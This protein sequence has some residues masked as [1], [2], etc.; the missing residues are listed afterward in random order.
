MSKAWAVTGKGPEST[1]WPGQGPE[2]YA[3]RDFVL[4]LY[5]EVTIATCC[6]ARAQHGPRPIDWAKRTDVVRGSFGPVGTSSRRSRCSGWRRGA[7]LE[8]AL[9]PQ[10]WVFPHGVDL[11]RVSTS[12]RLA[13][14]GVMDV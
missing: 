9:K 1:E 6:R 3:S 8:A 13:E 4:R 2:G 11:S 5:Y 14:C 10:G 7:A 12:R